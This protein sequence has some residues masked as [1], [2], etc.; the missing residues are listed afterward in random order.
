MRR[1]FSI[2][3]TIFF[4]VLLASLAAFALSFSSLSVKQTNDIYLQRQAEILATS[5]LDAAIFEL[6]TQKEP[7][8]VDCP[9]GKIFNAYFPSS[10]EPLFETSVRIV[11][12]FGD[13]GDCGKKIYAKGSY[14]TVIFDTFVKSGEPLNKSVNLPSDREK[15]TFPITFHKRSIQ[16]L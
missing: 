3:S 9:K 11:E 12:I 16:K 1:G 15:A 14:G 7:F 5:A 8:S 4:M 10:A 2:I 13:F 6:L